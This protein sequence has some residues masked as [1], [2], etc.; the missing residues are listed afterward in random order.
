MNEDRW[1]W[2]KAGV[3]SSLTAEIEMSQKQKEK[4]KMKK[5]KDKIKMEKEKQ[6]NE[7]SEKLRLLEEQRIQEEEAAQKLL[8]RL[9]APCDH[10]GKSMLGVTALL[11]FDKR[12]CSGACSIALRRKVT[13]EAAM[14]RLAANK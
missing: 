12:C 5:Q 11:L 10:C 14:N 8:A 4:D 7:R 1:D 3:G 13:A 9:S 6:E 2:G